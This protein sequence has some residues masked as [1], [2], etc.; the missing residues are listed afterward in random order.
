MKFRK[1]IS[2]ILA[3]GMV[4]PTAVSAQYTS[5]GDIKLE[6]PFVNVWSNGSL[7]VDERLAQTPSQYLF[8]AAY[9]DEKEYILLNSVNAKADDGIFVMTNGYTEKGVAYNT[10]PFGISDSDRKGT[11]TAESVVFDA[12][13]SG[14][15]AERINAK[16]YISTHFPA[17]SQYIENHT[18]YTEK[19]YDIEEYKTDCK[20]ALLSLTEYAAN[21]ERIGFLPNGES[22]QWWSRTPHKT[23]P[24]F[25]VWEFLP[26]LTI[27]NAHNL[28][29]TYPNRVVRP[30]FYLDESFFKEVKLDVESMGDAVKQKMLETVSVNEAEKL[31]NKLELAKIGYDAFEYPLLGVVSD[32]ALGVSN[33]LSETPSQY[34]F[35]TA[36]GDAKKY[37]LLKSVN[38]ASDD[39]VFVMTDGYTE[40][41]VAYNT[42]PFGISDDDKKGT[43]T[44]ESVKYDVDIEGSIAAR[45]NEDTYLST[46]FPKMASY[47]QDHTWYTEKGYGLEP[48]ATD[49]KIALLSL[50]EYKANAERIGVLPDGKA[51]QWWL[52][53]PHIG[54][55][56][57]CVWQFLVNKVIGNA[58]NLNSTY[59]NRV[60]RPC[61]YLDESFFKE[62]RL[63]TSSMGSA[64]KQKILETVSLEDAKKIYSETELID[65][66]YGVYGVGFTNTRLEKK[67][68]TLVFTAFA[69]NF[70]RKAKDITLIAAVY[71]N[72]SLSAINTNPYSFSDTESKKSVEVSVDLANIRSTD[73]DVKV[74]AFKSL[75]TMLPVSAVVMSGNV[76]SL[77][78]VEREEYECVEISIPQVYANLQN[79]KDAYFDVS[80]IYAGNENREYV[81]SYT[82]DD[83]TT[84]TDETIACGQ[85]ANID[86]KVNI[87]TIPKGIHT[88][89]VKITSQNVIKAE[90]ESDLVIAEFYEPTPLDDYYDVGVG[91]ETAWYKLDGD[92]LKT[93]SD[94]GFINVRTNPT[95]TSV[96]KQEGVYTKTEA[97]THNIDLLSKNG[98]SASTLLIGYGNK[99]YSSE[100]PDTE[101]IDMY[102]PI[103][104]EHINAYAKYGENVLNIMNTSD[105]KKVGVKRVEL[106]N[107]PNLDTYWG[108]GTKTPDSL[109]YI[110]M[111][112][113]AAAKIKKSNPDVIIS[114][115]ALAA[116]DMGT[117]N[118]HQ[119]YL[120]DMYEGGLLKY[121]DEYSVHPYMYP[122]NPDTGYRSDGMYASLTN[123]YPYNM[124]SRYLA[125]RKKYG[126]WIDVA[127]S[128]LGWPTYIDSANA[129]K[130]GYGEYG[131]YGT[132]E[133]DQAL[134]TVKSLVYND[135]LNISNTE[136]FTAKDRG[137]DITY[138]EHNFGI[139]RYNDTLKPA[140][141]ALSQYN[142]MCA[143]AQYIGKVEIAEDVNGYVYQSLTEPFM[144]MWKTKLDMN[145]VG[146]YT[147][148]LPF[149]TSAE[150]IYGN[151]VSGTAVSVGTEPVYIK[152][153]P[154]ALVK[155][156]L[157]DVNIESFTAFEA[158]EDYK[159]EI[160]G[161]SA[162]SDIPSSASEMKAYIDDIYAFGE[163]VIAERNADTSLMDKNEFMYALFELYNASK[164]M[165]NVL[166][167]YDTSVS[168]SDGAVTNAMESILA[169][170]NGESE[171]SIMFTDAI[172]RYAKRHNK[173]A[174]EVGALD[175]FTG[176]T[177]F[178]AMNDYLSAKLTGWAMA[179]MQGEE[180]DISRAILP[181]MVS[182][183]TTS[184]N[185]TYSAEFTL[186][187]ILTYPFDATVYISDSEGNI[188]GNKATINVLA[189]S[190]STV[191][192]TGNAPES[193]GTHKYYVSVEHDG[194]V[195][196]KQPF[197]LTVNFSFGKYE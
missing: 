98:M 93:L 43:K 89:K 86:K 167:M 14:T 40:G 151:P 18:W 106:W 28:N 47:I 17:M 142:N 53:T 73:F 121:A 62:V 104:R 183:I 150:D 61:F 58:H 134:Y 154:T 195:I 50:T 170:K 131:R 16:E 176:K 74:F 139:V 143:S 179:I 42:T 10:T 41:G 190:Y 182:K 158:Y 45:L 22:M 97:L 138:S 191:T 3:V 20:I 101:R 84:Q 111:M 168:D 4:L 173:R 171:S 9:G 31:Y 155:M 175:D 165:A 135:Y 160:N 120:D 130:N 194:K 197:M 180:N 159:D 29:S 76:N 164:R 166:A 21:A 65:I 146:D 44:A 141:I 127:V 185:S 144:I 115:G 114:G 32:T 102:P 128:E 5:I 193:A 152:N 105:G 163:A 1:I 113:R 189:N 2:L 91:Q 13:I 95:W 196:L 145:S 46:H 117:F 55:E 67:E 49:C 187:N 153:I 64:V 15:I 161:F 178:I 87:S 100:S 11:K 126:G 34:L 51:F 85:V 80:I 24:E 125:P 56:Y 8:K 39:G 75:E 88:L 77:T 19:G 157:S 27:G 57:Y 186:E 177:G 81:L 108:Y 72:G 109:Q 26:G 96:E 132:S 25:C 156:A 12:D 35:K 147:Y 192:L 188:C 69:S 82:V 123:S 169:K 71:E 119:V 162:L 83:W 36:D 78:E 37:I 33:R 23:L 129:N 63:D 54:L 136:V 60:V 7:V 59:T 52:R 70:E 118:D 137:E 48:Y 99:L 94:I 92:Y 68:N 140:A 148:T 181:Y 79:Q 90:A 107:E 116:G 149:N 110:Y 124:T 174:N 103:E 6:T 30:C 133:Y 66:G 172:M 38:S 184:A 122:K 112:N